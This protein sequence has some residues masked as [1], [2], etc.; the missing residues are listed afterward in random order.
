MCS[1]GE[2]KEHG[3][4]L[5]EDIPDV[6]KHNQKALFNLLVRMMTTEEIKESTDEREAIFFRVMERR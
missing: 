5:K 4:I 6:K 1:V 2:L 3:G